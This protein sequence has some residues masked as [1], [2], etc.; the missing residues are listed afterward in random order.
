MKALIALNPAIPGNYSFVCPVAP[1]CLNPINRSGYTTVVSPSILRGL[2][3]RTLIDVDG[4]IDLKTGSFK[5]EPTPIM[6]R[7]IIESL[8]VNPK[9]PKVNEE[10]KFEYKVKFENDEVTEAEVKWV[11]KE[12]SYDAPGQKTVTLSVKDSRGLW[13]DKKTVTFTVAAAEP[14]PE[15]TEEEVPEAQVAEAK[16]TKAKGKSKTKSEVK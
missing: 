14:I 15:E 16:E 6:V 1:L 8:S 13:S 12:N 5:T 9:A 7:P 4:V 11:G 3:G 2:K 10:V